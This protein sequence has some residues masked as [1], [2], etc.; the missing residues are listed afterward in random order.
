LVR[1]LLPNNDYMGPS[2]HLRAATIAP[3]PEGPPSSQPMP[4]GDVPKLAAVPVPIFVESI[5]PPVPV[6]VLVEPA[7]VP[8][9][10][11]APVPVSVEP[12]PVPV[13]V[14][15]A[16][17]PVPAASLDPALAA[18]PLAP[19]PMPA[20]AAAAPLPSTTGAEESDPGARLLVFPRVNL[21][22]GCAPRSAFS[23]AVPIAES[24]S[25]APRGAG[26][27]AAGEAHATTGPASIRGLG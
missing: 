15:P 18:A 9:P 24:C 4:S 21:D 26:L 12:A 6:P 19:E 8:V 7:P 3:S 27:R 23:C 20:A 10:V 17:V 22:Q 2:A 1:D 25:P 16:P 14:E 5:A 13:L 11:P